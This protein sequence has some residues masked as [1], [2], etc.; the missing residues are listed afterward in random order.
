MSKDCKAKT[1]YY[2][3]CLINDNITLKE[4]YDIFNH[5]WRFSNFTCPDYPWPDYRVGR[6][7]Q[8]P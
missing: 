2:S 6:Y 8:Y 4:Q 7:L 1:F 3:C 5:F